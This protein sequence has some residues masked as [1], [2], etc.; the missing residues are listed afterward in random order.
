MEGARVRDAVESTDIG[1]GWVETTP[2]PREARDNHSRE[3][4]TD[5]GMQP[6]PSLMPFAPPWKRACDA[7]LAQNPGADFATLLAFYVQEGFVYSGSDAFV[8][9]R[10]MGDP[11]DTWFIHLASGPL[12]R[13]Q[14]LAPFPL[15]WI[16]WHRRGVLKRHSWDRFLAISTQWALP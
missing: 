13:F 7:W 3:A 2:M 1:L 5:A 11:F 9:A 15:P 8:L 6:Q 12:R 10:P 4:S 14:E 16:G